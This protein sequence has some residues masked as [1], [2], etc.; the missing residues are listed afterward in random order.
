MSIV[1]GNC[2]ICGKQK[3]QPPERCSGHYESFLLVEALPE[4]RR[5]IDYCASCGGDLDTG[6]EC[7]RCGIDWQLCAT[8]CFLV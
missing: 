8:S 7:T 4:V 2:F 3:G 6:W 1:S 5:K